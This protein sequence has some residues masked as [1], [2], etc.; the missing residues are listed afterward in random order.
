MLKKTQFARWLLG[1]K[2]TL[3]TVYLC[4]KFGCPAPNFVEG[5]GRQINVFVS[6]ALLVTFF[7]STVF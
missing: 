3:D 5:F 1:N 7:P 4:T 6:E 2:M